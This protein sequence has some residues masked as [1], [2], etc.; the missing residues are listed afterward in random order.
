M[1]AVKT[2]FRAPTD[3]Q[4]RSG[5]TTLAVIPFVPTD[6]T[7]SD[8]SPL[9]SWSVKARETYEDKGSLHGK[10]FMANSGFAPIECD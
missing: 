7:K 8:A 4:N 3:R 1:R 6:E 2:N 10:Y 9:N 5:G